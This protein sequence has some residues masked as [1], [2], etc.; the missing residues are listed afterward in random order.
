MTSLAVLLASDNPGWLLAAEDVAQRA[1]HIVIGDCADGLSLL[2]QASLGLANAALLDPALAVGP[3]PVRALRRSGLAV[4]EVGPDASFESALAW[5]ASE[6]GRCAV[7]RLEEGKP[8][9]AVFGCKGAPGATTLAIDLARRVGR[10]RPAVLVDL[11]LRGGDIGAYLKLP[12]YPT[13]VSAAQAIAHGKAW[14]FTRVGRNLSV[15]A[16][17][18]RARWDREVVPADIGRLLDGLGLCV[19][20]GGSVESEPSEITRQVLARAASVVL[21]GGTDSVAKIHLARARAIL[22]KFTDSIQVVTRGDTELAERVVIAYASDAEE[23]REAGEGVEQ[24]QEAHRRS[25]RQGSPSRKLFRG[26]N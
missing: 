21:I 4:V 20:D 14:R 17:P 24:H 16:A 7:G 6:R 18:S 2:A 9:I 1:G 10:H 22:E 3:A 12:E 5:L 13:V 8:L 25:G 11:D 26:R 15:L 23:K 19:I